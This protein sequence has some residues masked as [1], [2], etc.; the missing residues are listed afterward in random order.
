VPGCTA[1]IGQ[2]IVDARFIAKRASMIKIA[3]VAL[4]VSGRIKEI[5]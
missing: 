1:I 2:V 3:S 4:G 5:T